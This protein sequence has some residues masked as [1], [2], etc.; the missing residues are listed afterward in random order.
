MNPD[1]PDIFMSGHCIDGRVL[2]PATGYLVL[3]W[4]TLARSLGVVM[5]QTPVIFEEVTIH[6]ATILPKT[7]IVQLEVRL[8]PA[9][10]RFEVS[11]SGNL[12][13]SGKIST[14]EENTLN[15]FRTQPT[16]SVIGNSEKEDFLLSD[17]DVY[18]ELR[19]RGYDYGPTFQ[20]I[21]ES[22]SRG[23]VFWCILGEKN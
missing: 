4:R 2:Y 23:E 12:A 19:L 9:S 20:G 16:D 13:A 8:M 5:E 18:K 3:A 1:S 11:E 15:D 14:M 21:I 6:R 10:K 7:G 17:K 22:N